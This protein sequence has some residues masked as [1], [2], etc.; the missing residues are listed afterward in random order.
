[1]SVITVLRRGGR[2][3]EVPPR[4]RIGS[5]DPDGPEAWILAVAARRDRAA[6]ARLHARFA[7]R[8]A[9]FL[10]RGGAA[11]VEELVQE[12]LLA[13]WRK[14][15]LFDP[16]RASAAAWIFTIARNLRIDAARRTGR[17]TFVDVAD[18]DEIDDSPDGE[19][20]LLAGEREVRVRAALAAL[21][22]EQ[23]DV[24]RL[25]YF[26]DK[27][28]VEIARDLG[29]PLGTVKSRLRL[30]ANRLRALLEADR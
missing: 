16:T 9:G 20:L 28:Q 11:D 10:G 4:I 14:A 6:F 1:M 12:T 23:A 21:P 7:P 8:L 18:H 15:H 17:A 5:I 22:P 25:T 13:V 27:P 29:I 3:S 26:T 30:A 2:L 19:A 24:V